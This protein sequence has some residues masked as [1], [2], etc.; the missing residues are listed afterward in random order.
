MPSDKALKEVTKSTEVSPDSVQPTVLTG[1]CPDTDLGGRPHEE[2]E[3]GGQVLRSQVTGDNCYA[4][5]DCR[6][7]PGGRESE[8]HDPKSTFLQSTEVQGKS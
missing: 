1:K 2:G 7:Q 8:F 3:G 6:T 5:L 4:D